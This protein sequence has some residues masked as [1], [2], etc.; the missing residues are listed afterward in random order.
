MVKGKQHVPEIHLSNTGDKSWFL[1]YKDGINNLTEK[2]KIQKKQKAITRICTGEIKLLS[3][4]RKKKN[5]QAFLFIKATQ[6]KGTLKYL[7]FN[8]YMQQFWKT[9]SNTVQ[10]LGKIKLIKP[11]I[12]VGNFHCKANWQHSSKAIVKIYCLTHKNIENL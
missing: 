2:P 8:Q 10:I 11:Y 9:I 4:Q 5:I 6:I 3:I 12:I 1:Y 7:T